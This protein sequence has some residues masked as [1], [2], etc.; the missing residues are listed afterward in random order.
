MRG[1]GTLALKKVSMTDRVTALAPRSALE[2]RI[3]WTLGVVCTRAEGY[4]LQGDTK[5][6]SARVSCYT[7]V[8]MPLPS[9]HHTCSCAVWGALCLTY[10]QFCS[11][12]RY[13]CSLSQ[14]L[15]GPAAPPP[16]VL[17]Q[18]RLQAVL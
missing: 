1:K 18:R 4:I 13:K 12:T 10:W 17:E 11:Q 15:S 2:G 16:L 6:G 14:A 7:S 9:F 5:R 3:C 8:A